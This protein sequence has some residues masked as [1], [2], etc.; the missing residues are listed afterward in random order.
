MIPKKLRKLYPSL[1]DEELL[2]AK[3]NFDAFLLLAWE[4]MED[5]EQKPAADFDDAR[6]KS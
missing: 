3:E 2:I 5:A 6:D 1:S 4:I